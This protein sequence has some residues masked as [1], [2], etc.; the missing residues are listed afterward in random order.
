M[1]ASSATC[2][3]RLQG[4]SKVY[5]V[6]D[7]AVRALDHVDLDVPRNDYV[8]IMGASGSGK[9]TLL[10]I[11]G[12]LDTPTAGRYELGGM[13]VSALTEPEA[14]KIRGAQ[15]G[16]IFQSFNLLP[17]MDVVRNVMLPLTL[18]GMHTAEARERAFHALDDVGLSGRTT[19][20]PTQLS[21]GQKQRVAIA[22]ALCTQPTL[23]LA[24]EPTGALDS[25]T[26]LEI[27]ALFEKLHDEGQ[28]IVLVTH[29][30]NVAARCRRSLTMSDGRIMAGHA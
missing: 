22:R 4:I 23:L 11:L 26:A 28:T 19:H 1:S 9:S 13:D 2:A 6:E 12:L 20:L 27:L 17:R 3:L 7:V 5:D 14:A 30:S 29:D 15:I 21:G 8:S 24:D 18:A 16:F 10:N 25:R